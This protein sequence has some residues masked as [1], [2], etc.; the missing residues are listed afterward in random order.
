MKE[1]RVALT[2]RI[3]EANDI[4]AVVGS[5]IPLRPVGPIFKGLCPFHDDHRPSLDV[6]PRR[7]RFRCWSCGKFG[8]V[9]KFVQEFERIGFLEA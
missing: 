5:Y 1:D 7:Q 4:V 8:D 2:Q 6:D 9:I 3:K